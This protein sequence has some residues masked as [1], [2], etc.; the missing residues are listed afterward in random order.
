MDTLTEQNSATFTAY[1]K[2]AE[3]LVLLKTRPN[4]HAK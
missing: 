1:F 2:Q 4:K 3:F